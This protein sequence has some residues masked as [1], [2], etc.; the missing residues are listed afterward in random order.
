MAFRFLK[1]QNVA[2]VWFLDL[3]SP[4]ITIVKVYEKPETKLFWSFYEGKYGNI[5][6]EENWHWFILGLKT[7]IGEKP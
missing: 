2:Q 5:D 1:T 6:S 7:Y 4:Y 3:N